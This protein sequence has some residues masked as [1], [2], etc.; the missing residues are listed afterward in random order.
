M[1]SRRFSNVFFMSL[2]SKVG[3]F[4][5]STSVYR[6]VPQGSLSNVGN[7]FNKKLNLRKTYVDI[8]LYFFEKYQ[9][10]ENKFKKALVRDFNILFDFTILLDNKSVLKEYL[11][12]FG[13]INKQKPSNKL[14]KIYLK[15]NSR[16]LQRSIQYIT[17]I[18]LF[19]ST[20]I[21]KLF[22]LKFLISTIKRKFLQ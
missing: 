10:E 21:N 17:K 3:Y 15:S 13:T 18:K 14:Y 2:K 1:V 4:N 5:E 6:T 12:K 11:D 7:D 16:T 8:R 19:G 22:N 20:Y 9:L